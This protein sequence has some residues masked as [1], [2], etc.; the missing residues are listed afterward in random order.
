MSWL[1]TSD[2][3]SIVISASAS[4]LPVNI[5]GWFP[6]RLTGLISLQSKGLLRII[7]NTSLK[8]SVLQGSAFFIVQLSRLYMTTGKNSFDYMNFCQQ[9][10]VFAF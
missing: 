9:S 7:S 4:V 1:F 2:A 10:D 3:Q 6:L 8:A 5:Q